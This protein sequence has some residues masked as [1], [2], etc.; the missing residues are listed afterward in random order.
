MTGATT[1]RVEK[2][3]HYQLSS[4]NRPGDQLVT[5]IPEEMNYLTWKRVMTNALISKHK[6]VFIDDRF[7]KP[8][9]GNLDEESWIT[10][11]SMVMS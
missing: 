1:T 10:Y 7:P 4:S 5:H 3:P 6:M 8:P 9:I 2:V 11:N